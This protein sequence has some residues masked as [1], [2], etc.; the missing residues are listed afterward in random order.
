MKE[1]LQ[2]VLAARGVA[3][4]RDAEA[5]I[6]AGRVVVEGE[7]V[8][9]LGVKVDPE[10]EIEVDGKPVAK[11]PRLSLLLHKPRGV[12]TTAHDPHGRPTVL[13]F[14]KAEPRLYPVGRLDYNSEGLLLLTND[15]ELANILTHPRY[16]VPKTYRVTVK[17]EIGAEEIARLKGGV[18]LEDGPTL[19]A[20]VE[21]VA[22]A[23]EKSVLEITLFEGR[24]RQVRRMCEHVGHRV[25]RLVRIAF[26]PL[27]LGSLPLGET[28]ELFA[29]EKQKLEVLRQSARKKEARGGHTR[30]GGGA[31]DDHGKKRRKL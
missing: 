12:L 31:R 15:G 11:D 29:E 18:K 27:T 9:E 21:L 23:S 7:V 30:F 13:D 14:V 20:E 4:R 19:P 25:T 16:N 3:S 8:A 10:A 28:R 17:G 2:K 1:R 22:A 6:L 24:K 5:L 26:G